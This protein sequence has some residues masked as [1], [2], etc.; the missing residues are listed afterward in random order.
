MS[1]EKDPPVP[2][3]LVAGT[4]VRHPNF[5]VGLV[6]SLGCHR[7]YRV[8]RILFDEPYGRKHL[9]LGIALSIIEPLP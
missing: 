1:I 9:G 6:E 5:G 7:G 3:W 2:E 8:A 4:H